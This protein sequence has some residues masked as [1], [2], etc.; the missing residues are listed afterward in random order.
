MDLKTLLVGLVMAVV[1]LYGFGTM[2]HRQRSQ[3]VMRWLLKGV[4]T[5]GE[6]GGLRWRGRMQSAAK[7]EIT[8][9]RT[10]YRTMELIFVL[11]KRHNPL[12]WV[13][14]HFKGQR[15]ELFIRADLRTAPDPQIEAGPKDCASVQKYLTQEDSGYREFDGGPD[16]DLAWK[17]ASNLGRVARLQKLLEKYPNCNLRISLQKS[18]PH[19][20]LRIYLGRLLRLS[21]EQFFKDLGEALK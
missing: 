11:E 14:G 20:A 7:I 13:Y 3:A 18:E 19:L 8:R 2:L 5:A 21:P 10:P 17:G 1:L 15:D 6:P 9:L 12:S 16:F 4:R